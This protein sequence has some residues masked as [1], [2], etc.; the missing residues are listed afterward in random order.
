L[1]LEE[2]EVLHGMEPTEDI[3]QFQVLNQ[4]EAVREDLLHLHVN[5]ALHALLILETVK[6]VDQVAELHEEETE[7]RETGRVVAD[8][9]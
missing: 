4:Q 5:L 3:L 6:K 1:D 8:Q 2:P 7:E 9:Q